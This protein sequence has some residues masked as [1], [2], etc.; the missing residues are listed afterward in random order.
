MRPPVVEEQLN[1]HTHSIC[2]TVLHVL[3]YGLTK[4]LIKVTK[5]SKLGFPRSKFI[6]TKNRLD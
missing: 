1:V 2:A 5:M 3:K 6:Y 4:L